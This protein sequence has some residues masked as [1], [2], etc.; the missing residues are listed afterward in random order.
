MPAPMTD[1]GIRFDDPARPDIPEPRRDAVGVGLPA[2]Q[3]AG[4]LA[5]SDIALSLSDDL[6]A[7]AALWRN[8]E[9]VAEGTFFQTHAWLE[10]WQRHV[11]VRRGVV[12]LVVT[13]RHPD[14][15]VLFVLPLALERRGGIRYLTCLGAA[16]CDYNAPLLDQHFET[17]VDDA[18]MA[19]LWA[20]VLGLVRAGGRYRFDVIDLPK[21]PERVGG[22]RNPLMVL[23]TRPNPSRAYLA[24]LRGDWET[25]Y[26]AKRSSAT[27]RKERKQLRQL[28]AFGPVRFVDRLEGDERQRTLDLLFEQKARSFA[29]MGV[30]NI[31]ARPGHRELFTG[32]ATASQSRHL[33]HLS[34][35]ETGDTVAA[36]S[37][38]LV[39]RGTY[40]LVVSSYDGGPVARFGPGRAHLNE[41]LRFA[42]D[43][44]FRW[45]DFTIGDEP[46][47][48]DWSDTRLVLHDH[49]SAGSWR[50]AIVV[51][52][53]NGFRAAKRTIKQNRVL[54]RLFTDARTRFAAIRSSGKLAND[55]DERRSQ[56]P[57][58]HGGRDD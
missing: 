18:A 3:T 51:G 53:V 33:V 19:A 37:I 7:S 17:L 22:Q 52:F 11:G 42:L 36:V 10:A 9:A 44:G 28:G 30:G 29:R 13:G 31:F 58:A 23:G 25:F 35:L 20:R 12:P 48:Q 49:L 54:W 15:Q 43:G 27:R 34:R 55:Q 38:G 46:Y 8:F 57:D 1:I 14:G 56:T 47:K 16:L 32:F 2:R 45:F 6:E 40:S 39:G 5:A 21:M 41:L 26:A 24:E 4:A 50:G